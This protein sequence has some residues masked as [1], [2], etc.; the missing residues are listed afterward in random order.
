[1]QGCCAHFVGRAAL[2]DM[3]N[4]NRK[5]IAAIVDITQ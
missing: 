1:M 3:L 2:P 4:A 5:G